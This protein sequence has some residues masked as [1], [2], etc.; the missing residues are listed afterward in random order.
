M[1]AQR[2]LFFLHDTTMRFPCGEI[3]LWFQRDDVLRA[4]GCTKAALHAKR[5]IKTQ[6]RLVGV[7]TQS[8]HRA[9]G[10]AGETQRAIIRADIE[11]AERRALLERNHING[12]RCRA[13]EFP[14]RD[15][16]QAALLPC[17]DEA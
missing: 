13:M 11:A 15:F 12:C 6:E 5:F 7:I 9:G 10:H 2:R 4:G 1:R 8:I 17:R 16:E 14:Q 3:D